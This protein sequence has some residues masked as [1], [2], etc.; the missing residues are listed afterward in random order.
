MAPEGSARAQEILQ[1]WFGDYVGKGVA[2]G[3]WYLRLWGRFAH[4]TPKLVSAWPGIGFGELL[5]Y[6]LLVFLFFALL[7]F[8]CSLALN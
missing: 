5:L 6:L 1:Y 3:E 7:L 4:C 2:F 8:V